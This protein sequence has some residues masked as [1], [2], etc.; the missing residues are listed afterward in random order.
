MFK[1]PK[2]ITL[3]E[4]RKKIAHYCA[5]Q[6]R[7]K[8]EVIAKLE[9]FSLP[10]QQINELIEWLEDEKYLNEDRFAQ[11]FASGKFRNNK[12]GK[13]KIINELKQRNIKEQSIKIGLLEIENEQY[14]ATLHKLLQ[15]KL[16]ALSPQPTAEHLQKAYVFA[17]SKGYESELIG[18]L[19]KIIIKEL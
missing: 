18:K 19:L 7:C 11:A 17:L 9:T 15:Q 8:Q 3:E 14:E 4:A 5:Y 10:Y 12:W 1:S 13:I 16:L 2:N 6:E